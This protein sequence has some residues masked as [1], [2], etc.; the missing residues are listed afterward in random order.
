MTLVQVYKRYVTAIS[1][2]L[3][4][5][6]RQNRADFTTNEE[7]ARLY[8]GKAAHQVSAL[9][10]TEEQEVQEGFVMREYVPQHM[11]FAPAKRE[12]PIE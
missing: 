9:A 11:R 6:N 7:K 2:Q 12:V 5:R 3:K 1:K 10:Y 4:R 8:Y